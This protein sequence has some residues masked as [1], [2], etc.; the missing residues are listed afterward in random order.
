[1]RQVRAWSADPTAIVE[2]GAH[3][4]DGTRIWHH[5]H[6]R[7]GATIGENTSLGKNVYIDAEV[8][9]GS[10]GCTVIVP[11]LANSGAGTSGGAFMGEYNPAQSYSAGETFLI[12]V[13]VTIAGIAVIAGYYGVPPA[14]TDVNGLLWSGTVPASPTGNAV[15]Q[16]PLPALGAAPNDRYY[17]KLIM[18]FCT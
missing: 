4:G 2:A 6:V 3:I 17:A 1:M 8:T 11:V 7:A 12:S 5:S 10:K 9:I 18:P 16:S 15:P 13:A 14:G